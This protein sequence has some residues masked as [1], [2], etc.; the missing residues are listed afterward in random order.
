LLNEL[1]RLHWL[2]QTSG[3]THHSRLG[4]INMVKGSSNTATTA[5]FMGNGSD[6]VEST[7]NS[8]GRGDILTIGHQDENSFSR[9]NTYKV[10]FLLFLNFILNFKAYRLWTFTWVC[11]HV[12]GN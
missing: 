10:T 1:L 12:Y 6:G 8:P 7:T 3:A 2:A 9:Q 11:K 4:N 5:H